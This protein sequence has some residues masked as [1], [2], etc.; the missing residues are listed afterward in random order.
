M[1]LIG[2]GAAGL[3]AL[4]IPSAIAAVGPAA[5]TKPPTPPG[6]PT[7]SNIKQSS[8]TLSWTKATDPDGTIAGYQIMKQGQE[9]KR[10]GNVLTTGLT[11]LTANTDYVLT[12]VAR[13]AAGHVSQDSA[14]TT[15]HT[16]KST[17]VTPPSV[18]TGL[19]VSDTGPSSVTLKWNASTDN[20]GGIGIQGYRVYVDGANTPTSTTDTL[21]ATVGNLSNGNHQFRVSAVDLAANESA[22][23]GPVTG[24]PSGGGGGG[25]TPGTVDRIAAEKDIPWGLAFLPGGDALYTNRDAFTVIRLSRS[26]QKTTV[27]KI[28]GVVGTNGEGGLLGLELD[29]NFASNGWVYIYHTAASDNRIIRL[30]L[31]GNTLDTGHIQTLVTGIRKNKFHNGGRLRFGPDGLLYASTGDSENEDLAQNTKSLNGKVLRL[32]PDGKVPAGNK[33]GNFVYSYGHRNVQGLAFD[34]QGRLWEAELGNSV[35]D[36]LNIITNGGNYGW[37][38]CEG[39]SNHKGSGCGTKGIIKPVRTWGVAQASPSG[40]AIVKNT[41]YMCALRG[42]RLWV[43]NIQGSGTS[44]PKAFFQGQFGRLRTVEP[45]PDGDIWVTTSSGDKDSTPNNGNDAILHVNLA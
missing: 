4:A 31:N 41:L 38:M 43:M 30:K 35:M 12:V 13:D 27:G 5:D 3:L 42:M 22:K 10:V 1:V 26:G 39:T 16:T 45:S 7:C 24:K 40:L 14:E 29:P 36:E 21:T 25:T 23:S 44:A 33:F 34:A 32:T 15:C 6:K 2:T 18:P 17:D 9:L 37:P 20:S 8:L 11:G 28:P 19:R